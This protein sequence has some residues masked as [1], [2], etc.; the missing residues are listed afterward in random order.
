MVITLTGWVDAGGAGR[1]RDVR[2]SPSSSSDA[3]CSARSMSPTSPTCSRPARSRGGSDDARV[4]STGRASRSSAAA[5]R[6]VVRV[7]AATSCSSAAR[8]RRCDGRRSRRRV[9]EAARRL[10]VRQAATLGGIPAL[11]SHRKAAVVT[12]SATQRS[13]AQEL[14]PLRPDYAGPTG[15]QTV[16]LRALGDAGIPGAGLWAQ[17]PQYVVGLAVAA[18]DPRAARPPGRGRTTSTR[19]ARARRPQP[20]VPAP[21]RSRARTARPD[22]KAVVDQIDERQ[23]GTTGDLV[24]EIEQFLRS[25][26]GDRRSLRSPRSA[27]APAAARLQ[28]P[29]SEEAD[30]SVVKINAITVPAERAD[31]LIARFANRA[32]EVSKMPGFEAF[33]LLRPTDD[34]DVFLVYTRWTHAGRLRE[35]AERPGVPA[36]PRRARQGRT[37]RDGQR[38]V[39]VRR[40]AA[41]GVAHVEPR[42]VTPTS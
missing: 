6:A 18:R 9:V 4:S 35:L 20:G 2:R 25:Q 37:G 42:S 8:S 21:G 10:G 33:E 24:A 41:R 15:L 22:V 28:L 7:R 27:A 26:P 30:M 3:R 34:R 39:V 19:P 13:L 36:G 31:E 17:V 40:R 38:A 12:A 14:A 29:T 16:V 5:L 23:E 11:V 1:G 32:G